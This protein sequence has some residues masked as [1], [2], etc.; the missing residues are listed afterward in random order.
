MFFS[1]ILYVPLRSS[2]V[3][4]RAFSLNSLAQPAYALVAKAVGDPLFEKKYGGLLEWRVSWPLQTPSYLQILT[5]KY[6]SISELLGRYLEDVN[7]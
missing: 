1:C 5:S 3:Q 6:V 4:V 7:I 2:P